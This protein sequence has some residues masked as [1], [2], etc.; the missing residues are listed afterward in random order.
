MLYAIL[1]LVHLLAAIVWLGGMFFAHFF[2][3][4]AAQTLEPA[5]RSPSLGDPRGLAWRAN[6]SAGFVTGM[7]AAVAVPAH[8]TSWTVPRVSQMMPG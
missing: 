8:S 2:L 1:K 6:G 4:P 3:R 5:L 7:A